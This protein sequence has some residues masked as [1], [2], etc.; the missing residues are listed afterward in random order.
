MLRITSFIIVPKGYKNSS[1]FLSEKI[2]STGVISSPN[3]SYTL[4]ELEVSLFFKLFNNLKNSY[5]P[6]IKNSFWYIGICV[7]AI[8]AISSLIISISSSEGIH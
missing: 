4:A 1:F 7:T 2:Q 5:S 8:A 3:S 6:Q